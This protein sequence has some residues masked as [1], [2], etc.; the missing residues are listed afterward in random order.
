MTNKGILIIDIPSRCA[1]CDLFALYS[2]EERG[3]KDLKCCAGLYSDMQQD[4]DEMNEVSEECPLMELPN[5]S[6]GNWHKLQRIVNALYC[7]Q[8]EEDI[9]EMIKKNNQRYG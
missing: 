4:F 7:L 2:D 9:E 1:L 3:I 8:K 5:M 6:T